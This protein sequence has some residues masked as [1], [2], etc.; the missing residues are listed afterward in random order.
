MLSKSQNC[1]LYALLGDSVSTKFKVICVVDRVS[2]RRNFA[3]QVNRDYL[4]DN[5]NN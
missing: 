3:S 2:V 1:E 5:S 4:V